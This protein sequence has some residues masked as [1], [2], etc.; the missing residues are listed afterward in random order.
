MPPQK[1]PDNTDKL[2]EL[3]PKKKPSILHF[4]DHSDNNVHWI[5]GIL[6]ILVVVFIFSVALTTNN[7][8]QEYLSLLN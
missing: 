7:S 6:V 3:L 2:K 5:F 8:V 1:K 4:P